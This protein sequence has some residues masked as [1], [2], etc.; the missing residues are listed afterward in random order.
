MP[1]FLPGEARH[2]AEV[3]NLSLGQVL[4]LSH[5]QLRDLVR[6]ATGVDLDD[7][8]YGVEADPSAQ[9]LW[10]FLK[11]A[12]ARDAAAVL[13]ALSGLVVPRDTLFGGP[14]S[15][16]TAILARLEKLG[17]RPGQPAASRPYFLERTTKPKTPTRKRSFERF[18]ASALALMAAFE[19]SGWFAKHLG[20]ACVDAEW[21]YG[22]AGGDLCRYIHRATGLKLDWPLS[23]P[24]TLDQAEL[25][26][27]IE[28]LFDHASEP[29]DGS[30]HNW[31]GCGMHW[32]QF[33]DPGGQ[34]HWRTQVNLLLETHGLDYHL[35]EGG[36][37]QTR[38]EPGL[39]RL[40]QAPPPSTGEPDRFETMV[41][42]ARDRFL[43]WSADPHE[44]RVALGE[45]AHAL[46]ALRAE[47]REHLMTEDERRLFEIAN[48]FSIRHNNAVQRSEYDKAIWHSWFF[49]LFL[50]TCHLLLRLRE[51]ARDETTE[52]DPDP[53]PPFP[54]PIA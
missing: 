10:R 40:H 2:L 31:N 36:E 45:L 15:D 37:I 32:E 53:T 21:L 39:A 34:E 41:E 22:R 9:R 42:R 49:Y 14:P 25:F 27:L 28:F 4:G 33:H 46:E 11:L 19:E 1:H 8:A 50:S 20:Q 29:L 48:Q 35:S 23:E 3:L 30:F 6:D 5:V 17:P 47:A 43:R 26:T 38:G 51:R 12:D 7:R 16:Y 52:Q 18:Q 13:N 54:G 44:R 24:L